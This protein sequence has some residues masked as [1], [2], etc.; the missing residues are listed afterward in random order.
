MRSTRTTGNGTNNQDEMVICKDFKWY[1]TFINLFGAIIGFA[2][3]ITDVL[4][5]V[6]FYNSGNTTWFV[7]GLV[8]VIL[9]CTSYVLM[10]RMV[11]E[12]FNSGCNVKVLL[13]GFNPFSPAI[14]RLRAFF[15]CCKKFRKL[16]KEHYF[17]CPSDMHRIKLVRFVSLRK[18]YLEVVTE[19]GPQFI[20]QLY[21]MSVQ[22]KPV[23]V[24]QLISLPISFLSLVWT[25]TAF[26]FW[27]EGPA[28]LIHGVATFLWNFC[29]ASGRL[30]AI[31]YFTVAFKWWVMAVLGSHTILMNGL[32]LWK[33]EFH[34]L[35]FISRRWNLYFTL[36]NLENWFKPF[37][38]KRK[39]HPRLYY[40]HFVLY[41][42]ENIAMILS[43]YF[44]Q[45]SDIWYSLPVTVL[46]CVFS[47]ITPAGVAH[48]LRGTRLCCDTQ[49]IRLCC[50]K[51]S[52]TPDVILRFQKRPPG[53][54]AV[55]VNE[56]KICMVYES[57]V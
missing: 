17:F 40:L 25:L 22:T 39:F 14:E 29:H 19:A 12:P 57:A 54:A 30:L 46:V 36:M 23:E 52:M 15:F 16:W 11:L 49:G 32:H 13:S 53:N 45:H 55:C 8:F 7:V 4:T 18:S 31:V 37:S 33:E 56:P 41:M 2:D 34:S 47:V 38:G 21:V 9:P 43:Y 6:T 42:V 48:Y 1:S 10:D 28:N 5:L 26:D 50:K 51:N 20:I 44:T 24:I 3:P 35:W 27:L